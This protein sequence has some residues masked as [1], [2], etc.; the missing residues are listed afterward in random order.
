MIGGPQIGMLPD[1]RRLHLNHGPIDLIVEAFGAPGEVAAAYRQAATRFPD[2]LPT[3]VEELAMLRRPMTEPRW[4][5]QGPVAGRMAAACWPHRAVFVTPMAAVAGAVADEILVVLCAGR[6][7]E[8]AY[9]NNGGDIAF[10][11]SPGTSLT[12]GL[13]A[14]YRIPAIEATCALSFDQPARGI[15]T[16][17]WQGR[18]FSLGIADSVTVLADSGAAA[19]VAATLIANAINVE[20]P[21]VKRVRAT[22]VDPDSDL[23]DRLVTAEVGRLDEAAVEAALDAGCRVAE[24]MARAGLIRAAVMVLRQRFRIAGAMPAGLIA[25]RAA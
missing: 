24:S 7:L 12:A 16:S 2:I 11:L 21:A 20:H 1:G 6:A 15:A 10:H 5:P 8:K 23:G 9:V 4:W 14:D 17:G 22:D 25:P 19:D 13:V 18:S 3:L